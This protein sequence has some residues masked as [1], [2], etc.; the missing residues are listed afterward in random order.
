MALDSITVAQFE[1]ILR[2]ERKEVVE[3][4]ETLGISMGTNGG[5]DANFAD[6]SQVTAERGEAEALAQP[7]KETLSEIDEALARIRNGTYGFC[8][9]CQ[10]EI[11]LERLEA[12]PKAKYCTPCASTL[13]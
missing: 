11:P 6:I 9:R 8:L 2:N 3:A 12:L 10:K 7:L 4:L 1:E 5:Y 13:R